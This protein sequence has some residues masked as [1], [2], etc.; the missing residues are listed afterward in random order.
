MPKIGKPIAKAVAKAV[1]KVPDKSPIK[2]AAKAARVV[3][4]AKAKAIIGSKKLSKKNENKE[5]KTGTTVTKVIVKKL[6]PDELFQKRDSIATIL[7]QN[8]YDRNLINARQLMDHLIT[9]VGAG[10]TFDETTLI[11]LGEYLKNESYY[12]YAK[13]DFDKDPNIK[14][15]IFHIK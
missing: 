5:F 4:P 3:K 13:K 15:K 7:T 10:G 6:T 8:R 11:S 9:Y 1:A 12:Y 14:S 2:V